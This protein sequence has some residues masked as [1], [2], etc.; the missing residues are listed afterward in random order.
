MF[1]WRIYEFRCCRVLS[2][3]V[4]IV[5]GFF[6][7][8]LRD[9]VSFAA[10]SR[11]A[12]LFGNLACGASLGLILHL[13]SWSLQKEVEYLPAFAYFLRKLAFQAEGPPFSLEQLGP[14][15]GRVLS[16]RGELLYGKRSHQCGGHSVVQK[17]QKGGNISPQ[18]I[19]KLCEANRKSM[20]PLLDAVLR[21]YS[22]E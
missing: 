4:Y 22:A 18:H 9:C 12:I 13:L 10:K 6:T 11:E 5:Q 21:Y 15:A 1:S 20:S 2:L 7:Y 19:V 14:A 16:R 8:L 17:Q 3:C